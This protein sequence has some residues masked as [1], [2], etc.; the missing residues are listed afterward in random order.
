M[1]DIAIYGG[2][3]DPP[4]RGH[5]QIAIKAIENLDIDKLIVIPNF[6]NP[7]KPPPLFFPKDRL[8]LLRKLFY[9]YPKIEVSSFEI[10]NGYPT[11]TI[12]TVRHFSK[13]YRKIY[14]IIGA[15]NLEKLH[16]W[17]DF[18]EIRSRV[19]FVVAT[20]NGIDIPNHFRK[21]EIEEEISSTKL[22]E[23]IRDFEYISKYIPKK[24]LEELKK[25]LAKP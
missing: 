19:E 10:D 11:K 16:L 17:D 4:H 6:Q 21:L 24:I 20:R 8:F 5:F 2:S 1:E 3:F 15:D 7:W 9:E 12:E 13:R 22:R 23:N 18:E 25:I 14:L